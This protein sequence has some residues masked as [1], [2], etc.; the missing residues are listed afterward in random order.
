MSTARRVF[1]SYS[2]L[3]V[4]VV[5]RLERDLDS[6]GCDVWCDRELSGGQRWWDGILENI[7]GCD[8]FVF[9]ISESS[10]RSEA[11]NRELGY[12]TALAKPVL[13]VLA[14]EPLPDGLLPP[15]LS[16]T[17]RVDVREGDARSA[18]A[19]GRALMQVPAPPPLPEPLPVPPP[20]PISYLSDLRARVERSPLPVEDQWKLLTELEERL[21]RPEEHDAAATLLRRFAERGDLMQG[22]AVAARRVLEGVDDTPPDESVPAAGASPPPGSK[23][24]EKR[25]RRWPFVLIAGAVVVA[26]A[27]AAAVMFI[28]RGES[29]A[30][31]LEEFCDRA[32]TADAAT[33]RAN[34]F[35]VT[36][37]A[38]PDR[39][40]RLFDDGVVEMQAVASS[41]PSDIRPAAQALAAA[42]DGQSAALRG[43]DWRLAGATTELLAFDPQ[44]AQHNSAFGRYLRDECGIEWDEV[45]G[46]TD[47]STAAEGLATVT[48][49]VG[50]EVGVSVEEAECMADE[51]VGEI[52]GDRLL[53]LYGQAVAPTQDESLLLLGALESC[54]STEQ[55]LPGF[56]AGNFE[57]LPDTNADQQE[58][59]GREV[60]DTIGLT[61]WA[62][63]T[64]APPDMLDQLRTIAEDCDVDPRLVI[65]LVGG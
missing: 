33:D 47:V 63:T 4:A 44:L 43:N 45:G 22:V 51:L 11:C 16:E 65:P 50:F 58:C 26:V 10:A 34:A 3:D 55:L 17:Q 56:T 13:P 35:L 28:R 36:P 59:L 1:V 20:V 31:S 37:E 46:F 14:G 38:D 27:A 29:D 9:A 7:R 18:L 19:L 21:T 24:V 61:V 25:R 5:E 49:A 30:D 15:I 54:L 12:A 23:D 57:Q 53:S 6:L 40:E 41:A 52:D 42:I 62:E 2:H 60:L 39:L 48:A 32:E 64:V 8:V